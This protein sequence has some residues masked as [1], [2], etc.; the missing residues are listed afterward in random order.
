[1]NLRDLLSMSTGNL[2]RMKLRAFLTISGVVIAIAAF[3]SMVSF[4][5][6]MQQNVSDQ[7]NQLGLLTTMQVFPQR[8]SEVSDTVRT[9]V[10]DNAAVA[11]LAGL[12]GVRLAYPFDAFSVT[13]A[14]ADTHVTTRAQALPVAAVRTKLF[15]KMAAGSAFSGDS[16]R[17]ALVTQN[18]L[19]DVNATDP[20]SIIGKPLVLSVEVSILDSGLVSVFQDKDGSIRK[21]LDEVQFDSLTNI[22]YIRNV[23]LREVNAAAQRFVNGYLN[24]RAT[25]EDTLTI[26]G[27]LES[28]RHGGHLRTESILVP[29]ATA[30][31]LTSGGFTGDPTQLM[32]SLSSGNLFTLPGDTAGKSYPRVTLDL[33]PSTPYQAVRDSV[34][35]MGFRSFSFAA[36]F[37]QIRKAFVYLD[38]ALGL[39][40][41]IA[42]VTASLGIVNTLVMS[43]IERRKEIGVL[44]SLGADER[45]IRRLFLVESAVIGSVG[46]IIGITF[47]WVITR[48]ASAIAK[49]V[50]ARE[51]VTGVELFAL[52]WWLILI[53]FS[54]GLVVSL[55][56]GLY[57]AARAA[58]VD[59]VE[60]LRNE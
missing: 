40:G 35:A 45:D 16:T 28:D 18:F 57:P 59:P 10:L 21:R 11:R 23:V 3:V 14:V 17:E 53:A 38:M 20:D 30:R 52:P 19:E 51:G 31:R 13:A 32:S 9:A 6:G 41:L 54:F 34:E 46:A 60:A 50:M 7:F 15:S 37:D 56:A 44:K 8:E 43:I 33:E 27:V 1:M 42:L 49:S 55:I 4:G 39:I 12:P 22:P 47:G 48:I 26:S 24:N 58:R 25:V 2:W 36:E 5:A 29:M